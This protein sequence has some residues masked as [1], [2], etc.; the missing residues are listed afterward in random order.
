MELK[1]KMYKNKKIK[2]HRV[3]F[4]IISEEFWFYIVEKFPLITSVL[5]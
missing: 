5:S 4:E 2:I 3:I 1:K